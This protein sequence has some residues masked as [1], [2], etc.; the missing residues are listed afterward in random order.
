VSGGGRRLIVEADGGSRG[1]PGPAAFGALVRDAESGEILAEAAEA[2]GIATNNV[3]E[4]RGLI[5]GLQLAREIDPEASLDVRMDSKLVIEQMAGAWKI[6]HADMQRLAIEARRLAPPNVTWT[7]VPRRQNADADALLNRVLDGGP[8][9]W[10]LHRR[11]GRSENAVARGEPTHS[12]EAAAVVAPELGWSEVPGTP[13]TL[14]LVRHGETAY[15]VQKRFSGSGGEDPP[16]T[17]HGRRQAEVIAADLARRGSVSAVISSPLRRARES[18]D[19]IAR[20]LRAQV[21]VEPDLAETAFGEWEGLTFAEARSRWPAE[22]DAWLTS[23][24]VPP[25]GGES[26]D[27]VLVRVRAAR[28]RVLK[29]YAGRTVALVTHVS[30]IKILVCLALDV[31]LRAIFRMEVPPGSCTELQWYPD[32]LASMRSFGLRPDTP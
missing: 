31:P 8:R 25:P 29:A 4:Y 32:G 9:V 20:A 23:T 28:D 13:T 16:L 24:S 22:L 6:K 2:I 7:H 14:L 12:E 30:P 15:S 3:A 18:A 19:I 1:N 17:D 5:A 27:D 10:S 11:P 26:F 21:E